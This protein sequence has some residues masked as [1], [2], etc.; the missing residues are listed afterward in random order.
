[1][2]LLSMRSTG[3]LEHRA[4]ADVEAQHRWNARYQPVPLTQIPPAARMLLEYQHL[5]PSTG[6]ALDLAC[7]LGGNALLLAARGLDTW[8]WDIADIAISRLQAYATQ[9][10][11]TVHTEV[12]D[13]AAHPPPAQSFDVIVVSRFLERSIAPALMQALKP[14]GLLFYQTLTQLTVGEVH[15][16]SNPAY[17]LAPQ[18]LLQLFRALRLV[19]YREE[20]DLG[21]TTQGWRNEALLI[22]QKSAGIPVP[23]DVT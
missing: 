19:V 15:K 7:G 13:V 9:Q 21:D 18:E 12:R 2:R 6:E 16:P 4:I 17:L 11:L 10:N 14:G 22:G 3:M 20:G 8:A 1:M 5:L 23:D